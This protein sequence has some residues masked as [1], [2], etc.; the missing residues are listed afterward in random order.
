MPFL[1]DRPFFKSFEV[2]IIYRFFESLS[3]L[4]LLPFRYANILF[5]CHRP[6]CEL[7]NYRNVIMFIPPYCLLFHVD[8]LN[9]L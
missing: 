7:L 2:I 3:L 6:I 9:V 5:N 1:L 4:P 8:A